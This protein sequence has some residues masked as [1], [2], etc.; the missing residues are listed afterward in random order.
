MTYL[1]CRIVLNVFVHIL[2]VLDDKDF[3]HFISLNICYSNTYFWNPF[4]KSIFLFFS[5]VLNNL[6]NCGRRYFKI[7]TMFHGTPCMY[8]TML[9]LKTSDTSKL[10]Y[11][12]ILILVWKR[13]DVIITMKFI[14]YREPQVRIRIFSLSLIRK[15]FQE[16]H[17]E[18][19]MPL[20]KSRVCTWHYANCSL[21]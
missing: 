6:T 7:F 13:C 14:S 15:R 4:Y 2:S 19:D 8:S 5:A 1:L 20:Y 18:S 16:Y 21:I 12:F 10:I 17:Q 3:L 11:G 9:M